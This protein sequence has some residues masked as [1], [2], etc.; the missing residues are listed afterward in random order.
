MWKNRLKPYDLLSGEEVEAIHEQA[1]TILEE[2]GV[3]FLHDRAREIFGQAGMK[4]ED[5]RVRFDRAFVM[6]QVAKTPATFDLQARNP[7]RSVILGG[8]NVVT[9]PVYGPPFITDLERGRRGATI[10]DFN[11]FDKMAQAID[12]IHCAGGTTVEPEDLPLGTRHLDMVYSHL[13]WTDKPF[14]GSVI[15]SENARDTIEMASIVFGG[16]ESIEKTPAIISLINVNSPLRYDDRMLGALLEYSDAGQ[17]VIVTPFLARARR[18]CT[19]RSSPTPTCSPGARPSARPNRR[20]ASS[21]APRWRVITTS[22][23]AAAGR[24]HRRKRRTRRPR[25][26]R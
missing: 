6:E 9:A 25:T 23:S 20:W 8:D 19:A 16:R 14:M 13:R 22:R 7:A 17:P 21:P 10:E 12:Q 15:S 26:N 4:V 11:N 2:I 24:S 3:D 5:N 18:A 1:M